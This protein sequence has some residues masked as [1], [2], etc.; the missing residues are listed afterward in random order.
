MNYSLSSSIPWLLATIVSCSSVGNFLMPINSHAQNTGLDTD[1]LMP[2]VSEPVDKAKDKNFIGKGKRKHIYAV[3][4][5]SGEARGGGQVAPTWVV[6]N[7]NVPLDLIFKD[8]YGW[9]AKVTFNGSLQYILYTPPDEKSASSPYEIVSPPLKGDFAFRWDTT[10]YADGTYVLG[11]K[12]LDGENLSLMRNRLVQVVI[13]NHSGPVSG[14]QHIPTVGFYYVDDS[15]DTNIPDWINFN[16]SGRPSRIH[17]YVGLDRQ[18]IISPSVNGSP[19]LV[20]TER[21]PLSSKWFLESLLHAN[22]FLYEDIPGFV[23]T[24]GGHLVSDGFYAQS[25]PTA[26]APAHNSYSFLSGSRGQ[27]TI[28][29]YS[30]FI[31]VP[32]EDT[33]WYG[34]DISGRMFLLTN[35]GQVTT[36]AGYDTRDIPFDRRDET[37]PLKVRRDGQARLV[38]TF[39]E[40]FTKSTDLT[41]DPMNSK[42]IYVADAGN[43]RIAKVDFSNTSG[44]IGL[45]QPNPI[46]TTYAGIFGVPGHRDGQREQ[47]L[48]DDPYSIDMDS[49]G[50]MYVA[51]RK[52][53]AIR[54]ID[55]DG[56][57]TTIAGG[58]TAPPVPYSPTHNIGG[59]D[60]IPVRDRLTKN[61]P[62]L[63]A[64][65]ALPQVLRVDS[66]DNVII[67]EDFTRAVRRLNFSNHMVEL[68]DF[69]PDSNW[70]TWVWLEVDVNGTIGPKDD[71]LV[72]MARSLG[73]DRRNPQASHS[74]VEIYRFSQTGAYPPHQAVPAGGW[75]K[76]SNTFHGYVGNVLE[77]MTH[78]PWGVAIDDSEARIITTGIGSS[79]IYSLRPLQSKDPT[80][81]DHRRYMEGKSIYIAGSVWNFPFNIRPGFSML[82]GARGFNTFGES[83][84]NFDD[85]ALLPENVRPTHPDGKPD[86]RAFTNNVDIAR[87]LRNGTDGKIKRP[88]L[89]GKDLVSLIYFV[90]H[91][92]LEGELREIDISKIEQELESV[93]LHNRSDTQGPVI[94]NIRIQDLGEGKVQL[95]WIT[96]EPAL[97]LVAYG[98][99]VEYGLTSGLEVEYQTQHKMVISDLI[100]DG[101]SG[102]SYRVSIYAKDIAGNVIRTADFGFGINPFEYEPGNGDSVPPASPK[103]LE[104]ARIGHNSLFN[105]PYPDNG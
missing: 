26:E 31:P 59:N 103:D 89:T 62:F 53:N 74:N 20:S 73:I 58:P 45:F 7:G 35:Q 76:V 84:L 75:G 1:L 90:R 36:I 88:E 64:T 80:E 72:A 65:I 70:G 10:Q 71:I 55:R 15:E 19:E 51:D 22:T 4:K 29:P 18:A 56:N 66:L 2:V 32:G 93:D 77:A 38:G 13:D 17:P 82:H 96:N 12:Y 27:A 24:P 44:K 92:S 104:I 34:I 49:N 5:F 83:V 105:S 41:V 54:K 67:A 25:G 94:S 63:Q 48:F 33:G 3:H 11:V 98:P 30:T 21:K 101:V 46:V 40:F 61:A 23:R 50:M 14:E 16:G 97:G 79:G 78:Y 95:T 28:S 39:D 86:S 52:N 87:F 42:I 60:N 81:Y 91:T 6:V 37:I 69:M 100:P 9:G 99:T 47:A 57:V 43:D 68:I 102:G 85:M 8:R